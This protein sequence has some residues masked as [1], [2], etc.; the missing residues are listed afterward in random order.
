MEIETLDYLAENYGNNKQFEKAYEKRQEFNILN[1]SI[2][3]EDNLAA[4]TELELKYQTEKKE[5]EIVLLE[6]KA[7]RS[8]TEKKA[9]LSGIFS[10]LILIGAIVYA[11]R[12]RLIKNKLAKEKVDQQLEYSTKE[13]NIKKQEL[14]A[15]AL[16][17]A[18]NN[19]VLQGIKTNVEDLKQKSSD[20]K[21]VQKIIN[22]ISINQTNEE[23]WEEFRSRFL[24]VHHNF[25]KNVKLTYPQVSK[26]ELRLMALLKMNLSNKEIANIL[27]ISGAGIKKARYRLRKKL[28]LETTDSL[29]ELVI[30]F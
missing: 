30:A 20:T 16:Q 19:E 21:S 22:T 23:T 18:H 26:N 15:Y 24:A 9:M 13:L 11:M 27:N 5:Q 12:Q 1:D 25:E 10:L 3:K 8:S 4:I 14:S 7:K 28:E 6:E 2:I 17:L 29:E